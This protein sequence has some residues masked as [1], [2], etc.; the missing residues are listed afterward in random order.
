MKSAEEWMLELSARFGASGNSYYRTV[1]ELGIKEIQLEAMKY[2]MTIA[3]K[4]AD[5][6]ERQDG[7]NY[8]IEEAITRARDERKSV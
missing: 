2:G 7:Q 4:I 5:T 1:N 6:I 3:A 8:G